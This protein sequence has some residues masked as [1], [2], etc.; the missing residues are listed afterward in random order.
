MK[1]LLATIAL[2]ATIISTQA[3]AQD[4]RDGRGGW[5]QQDMTRQ[6]AQQMADRCSGASTQP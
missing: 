6:Q 3:L 1:T 2:G 5:M 4:Q